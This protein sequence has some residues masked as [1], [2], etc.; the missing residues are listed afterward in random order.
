MH[1]PAYRLCGYTPFFGETWDELFSKIVTLQYS[2]GENWD[3]V[4]APAKDFVRALLQYD[5]AR[6]T[7]EQALAHPWLCGAVPATPLLAAHARLRTKEDPRA[8]AGTSKAVHAPPVI[9]APVPACISA[10]PAHWDVPSSSSHH[11]EHRRHHH[12]HHHHTHARPDDGDD[13]LQAMDTDDMLDA[14]VDVAA[15]AAAAAGPP[16][17]GAAQF[18]PTRMLLHRLS[19]SFI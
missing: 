16:E 1:A 8:A 3:V 18:R 10:D 6:L 19:D 9:S 5:G 12:H 17:D 4:S 14:P 15:A 7:S 2:F 13:A 11:A